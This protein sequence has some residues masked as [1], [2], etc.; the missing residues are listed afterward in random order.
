[1]SNLDEVFTLPYIAGRTVFYWASSACE[2]CVGVWVGEF[3]GARI[4]Q[5]A[6]QIKVNP[7]LTCGW[8][9]MDT[10]GGDLSIKAKP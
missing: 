8:G 6:G 1:M 3:A 7:V 2:Q 9:K 10:S 4:V 5:S